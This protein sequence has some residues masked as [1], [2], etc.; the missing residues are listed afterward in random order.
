[1]YRYRSTLAPLS[2]GTTGAYDVE[3]SGGMNGYLYAIYIDY[4]PTM[5][6]TTDIT[7]SYSSPLSGTILYKVNSNADAWWF[8][9]TLVNG[10][11]AGTA[12]TDYFDLLP[13]D[14]QLSCTIS[15]TLSGTVGYIDWYWVKP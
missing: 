5:S 12:S 2:P 4:S 13:V 7:I 15:Q 6:D 10:V 8:P 14:G 11:G 1:M 3:L 9:R